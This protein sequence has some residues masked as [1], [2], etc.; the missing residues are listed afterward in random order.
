LDER[1]PVRAGEVREQVVR[2]SEGIVLNVKPT[3]L[4]RGLI[5]IELEFETRSY[6]LDRVAD[7]A[8]HP[9]PAIGIIKVTGE[10]TVRPGRHVVLSGIGHPAPV[11]TR[12]DLANEKTENASEPAGDQPITMQR[13]IIVVLT[14]E[15]VDSDE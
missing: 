11:R 12:P 7:Q 13:E 1:Q 9:L 8:G 6:V 2:A 4:P 14:P 15:I 5:R 10:T 3:I